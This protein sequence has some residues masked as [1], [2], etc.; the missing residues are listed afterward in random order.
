MTTVIFLHIGRTGGTS[1]DAILMRNFKP[2]EIG[3]IESRDGVASVAGLA[4]MPDDEKRR[5][6]FVTGHV[7]YGVHE[8]L[9]QPSTYIT[10]VREPLARLVSAWEMICSRRDHR[11]HAAAVAGNLTFEQFIRSGVDTVTDNGQ[12]R[13]LAGKLYSLPFGET[14][15]SLLREA[16]EHIE[17]RFLVAGVT[18]RFDDGLVMLRRRLSLRH[19][20]H[21]PRNTSTDAEVRFD[22][23]DSLRTE[24]LDRNALDSE[25]HRFVTARFAAQFAADPTLSVDL[26]RFRRRQ[27]PLQPVRHLYRWTRIVA[28]R[29]PS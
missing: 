19:I 1:L 8:L 20:A 16:E 29:K 21:V 4:A 11:L 13:Q 15:P 3:N 9:P 2:A 28:A 24:I 27:A 7:D 22:I 6:R 18:E 10:F 25:L 26:S 14:T 17:E 23:S 5:L 12:V